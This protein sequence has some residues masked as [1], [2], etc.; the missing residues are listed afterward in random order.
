ME[1]RRAQR[2][3]RDLLCQLAQRKVYQDHLPTQVTGRFR[4]DFWA[5][6]Y[7]DHFE[8]Y[9]DHPEYAIYLN[10]DDF[11]VA[12][13]EEE[14][15]T[16][17]T[18]IYIQDWLQRPG[19][20]FGHLVQDLP[21][22]YV[23]AQVPAGHS[24]PFEPWGFHPELSRVG[25]VVRGEEWQS[26]FQVRPAT[27]QDIFFIATAQAKS[28]F[29]YVPAGR[30]LD[31]EAIAARYF[32]IYASMDLTA[33]SPIFGFVAT[34]RKRPVGYVLYKPMGHSPMVHPTI[35][36]YD[37]N[38]K[39]DAQNRG[40]IFRILIRQSFLDLQHRGYEMIIG[41]VSHNSAA[42]IRLGNRFCGWEV[43]ST[44]WGI[45]FQE[46]SRRLGVC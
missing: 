30:S 34:R 15:L 37:L 45:D 40:G 10:E 43:E 18:Q 16:G 41:D 19:D 7:R 44:R 17:Q 2:N 4:R 21:A 20:F 3:D 46:L 29:H 32:S 22:E 8:L 23:V 33:S 31:M 25:G 24:N 9:V 28:A 35:Y 12:Y 39:P 42:T 36:L 1:I 6:Y 13:R 11:L 38:I 14:N 27:P 5:N 26:E